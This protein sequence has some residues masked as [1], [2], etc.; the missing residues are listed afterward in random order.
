MEADLFAPV[1][2][3]V[4]TADES[5]NALLVVATPN[6]I[7]V[8]RALAAQLDVPAA[9]A[10]N[11]AQVFPL[12]YAAA[13]RVSAMVRDFFEQRARLPGARTE[14][15]VI[16]TTDVRTNSL[17]VST[18]P[19]SFAVLETLLRT[20]DGEKTNF[21]VGLHVI[22]VENG[23]V[24]TLA[25]RIERLMRERISAA[26]QSGA[27]RSQLD[28]FS[29]EPEPISNLLIV[30]CSDEN[31][32]VVREL[33][34]ALT[35]DAA[36]LAGSERVEVIQLS[37]ARAE[38]AAASIGTIYVQKELL[39][40][41]PNAVSVTPN[42]RL[43]A[44]VVSGNEQDIIEVRALV[45]R[46]DQAEVTARQQ[47]R[48]I[49]LKS[50]N[51]VE[52]VSLLESVLAGRPV[53]GGRGVGARQATKL[54]FLRDRVKDQLADEVGRPPTEADVDGAI[55]DQVT[56]T[57]DQRTNSVWITAPEPM[58]VLIA[59]MVE[60]IER[61]SAGSRRIV[62]FRLKNADARQMAELLRDTFSL[63]QQGNSLVLVPARGPVQDGPPGAEGAAPPSQ[64]VTPVPDE[65]QQLAIAIDARTNTLVVSGTEEYLELV[66]KLVMELDDIEANS[67][68]QRVYHLR[69]AKAKELETTLTSYF[70]GAQDQERRLL[71]PSLT[72]SLQRQLEEE[73]TVV[74]D[75][76]SNKIVVSTSPRYM[77]T[78]MNIVRELDSAPPQ[79]VIQVLL[80]EVTVD[81]SDEWGMDISAGPFGG[82]AF[83]FGTLAGQAG[84]ATSLG[85]PNLSVSSADFSLLIRALQAQG[86]LEVLSNPQVTVSN[87]QE[88]RIQVGENVAIVDGVERSSQGNSFADVIRQDV[89]IILNVV[90]SISS[91][92]FVRM[93]VRPEI[94]A[95]SARTVQISE[96][97][98]SPIITKRQ[99]E[100]VVT[101]KDAVG[102]HRRADPVQRG[103]A[104]DEGA[105]PGQHSDSGHS[106]P[107]PRQPRGQDGVAGDP[108]AADHSGGHV[109]V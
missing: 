13:D 98:E 47:I 11:T 27:V 70:R 104:V 35:E 77:E 107:Q 20:L 41:G 105:D 33:V 23:D 96:D 82:D 75:E 17:I 18:S 80:A 37:K 61:S 91:D 1:T 3:L 39:R 54:Q 55:K 43:N 45:N 58:V 78:V 108:D 99:V 31:L 57:A 101:V 93:D 81:S 66:S 12:K 100:T 29:I 34:R 22:A 5:L 25:P 6:N 44:L 62:H 53:G 40:R 65:R 16:V 89:G 95:L 83:R 74:G 2:G 109:G 51:A 92:G 46:L 14:D 49:E 60:D 64:N 32:A 76:N 85:V 24:R 56:L 15:A 106:V 79:V 102:R 69:N 7:A 68:E 42:E 48:W 88:A 86:K 71:G 36:R 38:E 50:A 10:A 103:A 94:S 52:V 28:A 30:A 97:V 21:S 73:V 72:G 59:E 63:R 9:S 8:V 84:V 87:N 26:A 90:P 19:R 67:R 4:V